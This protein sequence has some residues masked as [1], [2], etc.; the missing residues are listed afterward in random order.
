MFPEQTKQLA[1]WIGIAH[2]VGQSM[3]Y[4]LLPKS[5]VPIAR[6]TIQKVSTEE[7]PTENFQSKL[8]EFNQTIEDKLGDADLEPVALKLYREDKDIDS[9]EDEPFDPQAQAIEISDVEIDA[10]DEL[11]LSEPI[12]ERDGEMMRAQIIG[13]KRGV[14]GNF[15]GNGNYNPNPLLNMRI[16]LASFPDGHIAEY[17]VNKIIEAIYQ[18]ATNDGTDTLFFDSIIGHQET[19]SLQN[20]TNEVIGNKYSTKGRICVSWKDGTMSWH[21]LSNVKNS[22]PLQLAEYAV[23]HQLDK[24]PAF[25]WWVKTAIKHKRAYKRGA[26]KSYLKKSHKFGIRVPKTV[27]EQF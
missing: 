2:R 1:R 5:G 7:H 3:R 25:S 17:G 27:E 4:W 23:Y 13:R 18:N 14:N 10:Y 15:A 8:G 20:E 21:N 19:S 24:L 26:S 16:Y 22:Y 6:T 12:L 11:L 9:D